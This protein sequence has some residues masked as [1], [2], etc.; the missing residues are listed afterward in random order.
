MNATSF[1]RVRF[2]NWN[3]SPRK[4]ING[5]L[6]YVSRQLQVPQ[7]LA[8]PVLCDFG[9]AVFGDIQ[10]DDDVQPDV[11]RSPEVILEVPWSYPIDIWNAGCMVSAIIRTGRSGSSLQLTGISD[12]G[13]L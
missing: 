9:S 8:A 6:I 5:R 4:E 3:P 12:L 7:N 13:Y 10:R 2:S 1:T 11:Y